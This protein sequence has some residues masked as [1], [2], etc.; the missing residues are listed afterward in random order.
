MSRFLRCRKLRYQLHRGLH[1]GG[2]AQAIPGIDCDDGHDHLGEILIT[3]EVGGLVVGG[4]GNV[5]MADQGDLFGEREYG[6]F[7]GGEEWRFAPGV[8][9]IDTLFGFT[10]FAGVAG[11]HVDA[12]GTA[13][14][15]G[16][17]DV[18]EVF[19]RL[20]QPGVAEVLFH[21]D[22]LAVTGGFGLV[23]F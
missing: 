17:A 23:E 11:V 10:V 2:D 7:L 21:G 20:L 13:V 5:V 8:E 12:K 1:A 18:D 6:P 9:G 15:L 4:V 3:E 19:V 22:E 16:G 14:D